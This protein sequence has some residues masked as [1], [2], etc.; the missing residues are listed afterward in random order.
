MYHIF[1]DK[2]L[3]EVEQWRQNASSA[4][5]QLDWRWV[6][7]Y[8]ELNACHSWLAHAGP[9]TEEEQQQGDALFPSRTQEFALSMCLR[10]YWGIP[11]L[12]CASC[13]DSVGQRQN[14]HDKGHFSFQMGSERGHIKGKTALHAIFPPEIPLANR[15]CFCTAGAEP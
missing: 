15:V 8:R 4:Q 3:E 9:F 11:N 7:R 14:G 13:F 10:T 1:A 12:G 6:E 5:H 2:A